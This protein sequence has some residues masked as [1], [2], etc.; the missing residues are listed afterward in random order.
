MES[1][2]Y[3]EPMNHRKVEMQRIHCCAFCCHQLGSLFVLQYWNVVGETVDTNRVFT[4]SCSYSG[5]S[6]F[7]PFTH[8]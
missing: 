8:D 5:M 1:H 3:R 2:T 7:M 4:H 6:I